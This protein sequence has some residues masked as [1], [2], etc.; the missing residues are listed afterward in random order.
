MESIDTKKNEIMSA[1]VSTSLFPRQNELSASASNAEQFENST[2]TCQS[3][4]VRGKQ[5]VVDPVP[6]PTTPQQSLHYLKWSAKD[7]MWLIQTWNIT[8][9]YCV[10]A[11]VLGR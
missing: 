6:S 9:D 1:S 10:A 7:Y 8:G 2:V 11:K 5:E 4:F 3:S